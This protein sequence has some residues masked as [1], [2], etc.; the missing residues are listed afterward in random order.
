M[1]KRLAQDK[2]R[3]SVLCLVLAAAVMVVLA[4]GAA[5]ARAED[6][7]KVLTLKQSV[8]QALKK[9]PEV[10]SAAKGV[11]GA[12]WKRREAFTQFLPTF[13][14]TYSYTKLEET[15]RSSAVNLSGT[16]GGLPLTLTSPSQV[17]GSRDNWQSKISVTQPLFT[18]FAL[19]TAYQMAEMGVDLAKISEVRTRLDIIFKAKQAYLNIILAE[20]ATEIANQAYAQNEAHLNVAKNFYE[21]GMVPKNQVLQA[22]ANL[23]QSALTKIKA[24][25]DVLLAKASMN[26]LLRRDLAADLEVEDILAYKP[27]ANSLDE[28]QA[29]AL[30]TRPEI[31]A[32]VEQVQLKRKGVRLAKADF[33]PTVALVGNYTWKGDDW[34]VNGSPYMDD[35]RSWDITAALTWEFWNWGRTYDQMKASQTELAQAEYTLTQVRDGVALEVKN[36]YLILKEAERAIGA[37]NKAVESAQ[38]NFRMSEERYREQV[39]TSTEVLDALTLL[40]Q[41]QTSL[42]QTLYNYNLAWVSL[43]RAMGLGRDEI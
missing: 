17:V 7:A 3:S 6:T 39:A 15:P 19:T 27:F 20:K 42:Y 40:T 11:E 8:A 16:W 5:P 43:E 23:A 33:Y 41:A 2:I 35:F 13:S 37:A 25:N 26:T 14:A 30:K 38:E 9:S 22:E 31:Q 36:D 28:C 12:A 34:Q 1:R 10:A 18:G 32:V 21:V 29:L 24:E 4:V